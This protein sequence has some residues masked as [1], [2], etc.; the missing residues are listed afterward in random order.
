MAIV[1][2]NSIFLMAKMTPSDNTNIV[3]IFD[4]N[5]CNTNGQHENGIP[6]LCNVCILIILM[7][8][9]ILAVAVY[10]NS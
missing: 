3:A 2:I 7:K 1:L 4:N 9:P 10:Y 8:S 5:V 6:I